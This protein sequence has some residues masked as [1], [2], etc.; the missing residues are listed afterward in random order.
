MGVLLSKTGIVKDPVYLEHKP[1]PNHPESP[2]RLEI[3]YDMLE[4]DDMAGT[5]K[6]IKPRK[7]DR[8]EIELIHEP[9]YFNQVLSTAGL[10]YSYLD[11]DTQTSERSFEAALFA[12]GGVLLGIDKIMNGEFKNVFALVRPPGHHAE[13]NRGMG[14]C[15][16][17]NVAV[18]AM[19]AIKKYSIDRVLI[20]DW[21]LHHGNGTQHSFYTDE[22]VLYFSTHQ[23]P[24]YPGSGDFFEVG[25]GK[26]KGFTINIPLDVGNGDSEYYRIFKKVLEPIADS[27]NPQ[28]V[29]VSAGF[30]I[31][32]KDPLGGMG[33]TP[34]GFSALTQVLQTIAER[35]CDKKLLITL[36][37]GYDL[38][39]LRDSVK[40]VIK[41]L[42]GSVEKGPDIAGKNIDE[43]GQKCDHVIK[44]V[45][46]IQK[47]YWSCF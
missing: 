25:Q 41:Q 12:V 32:Y 4:G 2:K 8:E 45:I 13:S 29:L 35:S 9:S 33:V 10:P 22:R 3:L 43:I 36:E 38:E 7:A 14:F 42:T 19:Y 40:S 31:Y 44:K 17:N 28:L 46:S 1:D 11:P 47:E 16:F 18:A 39:G 5:F 34:D 23:F 27:Y 30:D 6:P 24:Y 15:L 20:V 21:D 37:G 26:G